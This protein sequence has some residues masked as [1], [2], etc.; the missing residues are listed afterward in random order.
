VRSKGTSE[1]EAWKVRLAKPKASA[2]I[3]SGVILRRQFGVRSKGTSEREAWKVRLAKPKASA[4]IF[5]GVILRR[6]FGVR[7]KRECAEELRALGKV[8]RGGAHVVGQTLRIGRS[9]PACLLETVRRYGTAV[10]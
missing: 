5:S 10:N 3:F 2:E 6:R 9:L 7:S 1:R 8:R 4:E